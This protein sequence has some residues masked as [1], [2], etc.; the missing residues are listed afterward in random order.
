LGL[1]PLL[2][3]SFHLALGVVFLLAQRLVPAGAKRG[4]SPSHHYSR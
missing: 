2:F 3:E 1:A 4:R